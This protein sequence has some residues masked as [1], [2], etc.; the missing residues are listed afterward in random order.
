M[1]LKWLGEIA[2]D[3]TVDI[4]SGKPIVAL[5][6]GLWCEH[7]CKIWACS[8]CRLVP[9]PRVNPGYTLPYP[10]GHARPVQGIGELLVSHAWEITGAGTSQALV[11]V[12]LAIANRTKFADAARIAIETKITGRDGK[13]ASGKCADGATRTWYVGQQVYV[14]SSVEAP[15]GGFL[16]GSSPGRIERI[17]IGIEAYM[18]GTTALAVVDLGNGCKAT[19]ACR[20]LRCVS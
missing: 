1:R 6:F 11:W 20:L 14:D 9:R 12:M 15:E 8:I 3:A 19:V 2:L 4:M 13:T 5:H 17:A 7:A 10:A 18:L 16:T